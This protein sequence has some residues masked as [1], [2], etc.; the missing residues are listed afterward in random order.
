MD[1]DDEPLNEL[2]RRALPDYIKEEME[3]DLIDNELNEAL[4]N[5]M[6]PNSAPGIDGFTVKFIIVFWDSLRDL[7]RVAVNS[8]EKQGQ[9]YLTLRLAIIKLLLKSGKDPTS[10]GS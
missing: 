6:K 2:K 10:P 4:M 8:M 9:M 5:N 3:R 7:L 1:D